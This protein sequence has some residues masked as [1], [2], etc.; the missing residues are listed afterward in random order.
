MA[1]QEPKRATVRAAGTSALGAAPG[2]PADVPKINAPKI[3]AAWAP[4]AGVPSLEGKNRKSSYKAVT[5]GTGVTRGRTCRVES[6]S[7][8][9]KEGRV[10]S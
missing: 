6:S 9:A 3:Y 7:P 1:V 2:T 10:H 8:A 4:P 5:A